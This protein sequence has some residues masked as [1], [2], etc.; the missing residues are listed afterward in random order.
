M[1]IVNDSFHE[2]IF[3]TITITVLCMW[4][5]SRIMQHYHS[6]REH[7]KIVWQKCTSA[8]HNIA[9]LRLNNA[10]LINTHVNINANESKQLNVITE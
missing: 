8:Q 6:I 9:A 2:I 5:R 10:K 1:R 7:L 3:G 4:N